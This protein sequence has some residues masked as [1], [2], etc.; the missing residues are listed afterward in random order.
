MTQPSGTLYIV[1]TPI[2]DSS[3][4]TARAVQTLSEVDV[5]VCEER[6]I[7]ARLL[8]GL[9]ITKPLIELNEHNE[10]AMIQDIL[11]DLMNGKNMALISDC[12]TPL[13]SDPGRQLLKLLLEMKVRIIPV[14][15]VSSLMTAISICP[16]DLREYYFGGF[17][18]PKTEQR[19]QTLH[20]LSRMHCPIIL[21]DTPYRLSKLLDEVTQ[22]FGK[23]QQVFLACDLTTPHE[24]SYIGSV[25]EVTSAVQSRKAEF[26]LIIDRPQSARVRFN[27]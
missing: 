17:L 8:K 27:G 5:V 13:F 1:A 10:D 24:R 7:G 4:I 9:E 3:D 15:G 14:P 18:P 6:K 23:K 19:Q 20:K 12:G 2:G 16:F 26:I 11:I 22:S 21:M 25:E